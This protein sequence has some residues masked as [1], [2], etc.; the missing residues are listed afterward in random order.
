MPAPR[1]LALG[2]RKA[3]TYDFGRA[4][5]EADE[6]L[7][8][9]KGVGEGLDIA[10]ALLAAGSAHDARVA[11]ALGVVEG[12]RAVVRGALGKIEDSS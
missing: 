4:S 3:V 7:D 9:L 11:R 2:E 8:V 1:P 6:R 5:A 10:L 12:M